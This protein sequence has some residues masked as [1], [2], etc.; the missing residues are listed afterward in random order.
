MGTAGL[1]SPW[2]CDP[3][4][5]TSQESPFLHAI[6]NQETAKAHNICLEKG[7]FRVVLSDLKLVRL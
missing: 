6:G 7:P 4:Q 3:E 2:L 5:V 1:A